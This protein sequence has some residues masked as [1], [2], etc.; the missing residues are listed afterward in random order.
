MSPGSDLI[1]K[2]MICRWP[3]H[4]SNVVEH[5]KYDSLHF[6]NMPEVRV[7]VD[8]ASRAKES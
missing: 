8:R 3:R 2:V 5:N 7:V 6:S 4:L 1:D